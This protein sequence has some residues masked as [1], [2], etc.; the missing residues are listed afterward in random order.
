MVVEHFQTI[1]HS[2]LAAGVV[3]QER[4]V[5][6]RKVVPLQIEA[7]MAATAQPPISPVFL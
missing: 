7:V 4:R 2:L 6:T 1:Q 5:L 3:E